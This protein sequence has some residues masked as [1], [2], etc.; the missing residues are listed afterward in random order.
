MNCPM[1]LSG[2][3]FTL[4]HK[5]TTHIRCKP[6]AN[7]NRNL[8]HDWRWFG[9]TR[10]VRCSAWKLASPRKPKQFAWLF[11][12][13]N[14]L[15][16]NEQRPS[17]SPSIQSW[18]A[19]VRGAIFSGG[20][21]QT[22]KSALSFWYPGVQMFPS[23]QYLTQYLSRQPTI[24]QPRSQQ[25][26]Q[27]L[28]SC[29]HCFVFKQPGAS[30]SINSL[31]KSLLFFFFFFLQG[32]LQPAVWTCSHSAPAPQTGTENSRGVARLDEQPLHGIPALHRHLQ[33][34]QAVIRITLSCASLPQ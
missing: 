29:L 34:L 9:G 26:P 1:S 17:L 16:E 5:R 30:W 2:I 3:L 18:S 4:Q 11:S 14:D 27:P 32:P 10:R 33:L 6:D 23:A 28:F 8:Y 21:T 22:W 20:W 13:P 15:Q 19:E 24:R 12:H 25:H 7:R 31:H